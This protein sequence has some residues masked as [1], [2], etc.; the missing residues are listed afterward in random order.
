MLTLYLRYTIDPNKR[1]AYDA[2]VAAEMDP[3]TR[4]GGKIIGYF[5]PT[6]YAG[7]TSEAHGL[8]EFPSLAAY[9]QYRHTL[10][11]DAAHKKNVAEIEQ[12]GAVL[13]ITRSIVKRA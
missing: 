13:S 12:S 4:S 3:I 2:Y 11:G 9:E 5:L 1:S 7:A 8:I 6:D 10:A